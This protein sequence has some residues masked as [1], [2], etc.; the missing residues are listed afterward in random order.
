MKIIQADISHLHLI[1][2]LFDAYRQFYKQATDL[3]LAEAF[4][5]ERI[6]Q[7]ESVIFLAMED[8]KAVGFTQLYPTFSS[9]SAQKTWVL[10]DLFVLPEMRGKRV[11]E[12][13]L[14][15]AQKF[16]K[17]TNGKGLA[18]ETAT[19]NSAQKLYE[20]LG[21]QKDESYLHYFWKTV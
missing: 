20:K 17:E 2:P 21:W 5:K 8:K 10:N 3:S 9:V 12:G 13:I 7:K 1:A 18:L 19:D 14:K 11:G 6:E 16:V 4:L 15:H